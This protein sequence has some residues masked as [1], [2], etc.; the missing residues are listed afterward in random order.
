MLRSIP[1]IAI[2]CAVVVASAPASLADY[3]YN[4]G[5]SR[6][7]EQTEIGLPNPSGSYITNG[8]MSKSAQGSVNIGPQANPGLPRVNHGAYIGTPGDNMYGAHPINAQSDQQERMRLQPRPRF[9]YLQQ[10]QPKQPKQY[11]Y[12]PGQHGDSSS[13]AMTYSVDTGNKGGVFKYESNTQA[14]AE[15]D[16]KKPPAR[17][18]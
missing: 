3:S 15:E 2:S 12:V 5:G 7:V 8:T 1:L 16:A 10:P 9:I 18:F 14:P 4:Y 13:G 11:L 6:V 17:R